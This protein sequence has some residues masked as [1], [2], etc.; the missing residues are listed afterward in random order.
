[1]QLPWCNVGENEKDDQAVKRGSE[2]NLLMY[3]LI[4]VKESVTS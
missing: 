3:L 2:E 1:M 4:K